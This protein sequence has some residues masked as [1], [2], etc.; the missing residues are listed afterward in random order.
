MISLNLPDTQKLC[1]SFLS[2]DQIE[3]FEEDLDIDLIKTLG[4]YRFR[5]NLS[6]NNGNVGAVVRILSYSPMA[7]EDIQLPNI[8]SKL[9]LR[10][11]GLILITGTTSQG[12][13]TTLAAMV[14][15]INKQ[16]NKHI[17]TIEEPIEYMHENIHSIVRQR[18]IGRDTKNFERGMKAALR[19]DP[20]VIVIGEMR[21][22]ESIHIALTAAETGVLVLS[23]LRAISVDKILDRM[24]SYVPPQQERQIRMMLS[25]ALLGVIH[26]ELL[27]TVDG[28]KRVACEILINTQAIRN[29][30]RRPETYLLKNYIQTSEK[31]YG[32]R[33]MRHSLDELLESG[34]ITE[35]CY[36]QVIINY[37]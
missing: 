11:K 21:D 2:D 13:T 24:F 23:T 36:D 18:E 6:Y 4:K 3:S 22:F 15:Y 37:D 34:L 32:M 5:I 8:V 26:Q 10:D 28:G 9:C 20:D 1:Y 31:R 17:I 14:D 16:K 12:K 19:Q 30:L 35:Q 29:V 7:L 25:E 33:T 27:S